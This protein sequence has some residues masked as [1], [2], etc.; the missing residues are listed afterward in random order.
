M[1]IKT[2]NTFINT[3]SKIL[4]EETANILQTRPSGRP[5]FTKEEYDALQDLSSDSTIAIRPADKGGAVVVMDYTYY[6]NEILQQLSDSTIYRRLTH[7]PTKEYS[8]KIASLVEMGLQAGY[9]TDS[10]ATFLVVKHPITPVLYTLP[11]IHKNLQTPPGRPIVSARGSLLEPIGKYIDSVTKDTMSHL[12][13]CIKDTPHFLERIK[14]LHLPPSPWLMATLDVKS[15]YTIIPHD[16]GIQCVQQVLQESQYYKGP[17]I[18]FILELLRIALYQNFFKFENNLYIQ[19]AG[20]AMGASMAPTYANFY[21][22]C[23]EHTHLLQSYESQILFYCRFV[24]DIFLIWDG[25]ILSFNRM[26]DTINLLDTPVKLSATSSFGSIPFLD[27]TIFRTGNTLGYTLFRKETDRNTILHMDS[28][29]PQHL[30]YSLPMSQFLRVLRYNSDADTCH[31]QIM[32]MYQR[33]LARG[34]STNTLDN[35]LR[36]ANIRLQEPTAPTLGTPS[37][38]FLPLKFHTHSAKIAHTI[39]QHWNNFSY[40]RSLPIS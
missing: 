8:D 4:Q 15:L 25:D 26:V 36:K 2:G 9:I 22:F 14:S 21:M 11:K 3:F 39:M 16:A 31:N 30:K 12:A 34:Y 29:H 5:N 23:F 17:P 33:F 38:I 35:A 18:E 28:H 37:R 27:V 40:D 6:R 20:M 32:E 10:I 19:C 24:D 1:D 7:D 13:T